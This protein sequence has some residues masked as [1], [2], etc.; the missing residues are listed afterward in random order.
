MSAQRS[1]LTARN[2]VG[3]EDEVLE[4]LKGH[5]DDLKIAGVKGGYEKDGG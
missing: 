4:N 3:A 1:G 2:G 5:L